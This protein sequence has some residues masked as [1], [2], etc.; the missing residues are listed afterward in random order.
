MYNI[1]VMAIDDILG[2]PIRRAI[3]LQ[4]SKAEEAND[5]N[6]L[7]VS[8]TKLC[9]G[10][11]L[12]KKLVI[13][14]N[15]MILINQQTTTTKKTVE[16]PSKWSYCLPDVLKLIG[17]K[18]KS[19]SYEIGQFNFQFAV[20]QNQ[21]WDILKKE[22]WLKKQVKFSSEI[23]DCQ[24]VKNRIALIDYLKKT[25]GQPVDEASL[26]KC[27]D[28][29]AE[30]VRTNL[31]RLIIS[32]K[33]NSLFSL[34][35]FH[36]KVNSL[37]TLLEK[38][39]IIVQEILSHEWQ[40]KVAAE[41]EIVVPKELDHRKSVLI[42][43]LKKHNGEKFVHES[44]QKLFEMSAEQT[45]SLA[46]TLEEKGVIQKVELCHGILNKEKANVEQLPEKLK[47][48]QD[49]LSSWVQQHL[50]SDQKSAVVVSRD[51]LL[52]PLD[53]KEDCRQMWNHLIGEGVIKEPVLVFPKIKDATTKII[54]SEQERIRTVINGLNI[55]PLCRKYC[56][57]PA[58]AADDY[59][60]GFCEVLSYLRANPSVLIKYGLFASLLV[61]DLNLAEKI[62]KEEGVKIKSWLKETKEKEAL[63]AYVNQVVAAVTGSAGQLKT[64]P[65]A[66]SASF[67][68][69][70]QYFTSG[71][72]PPEVDDF[73]VQLL[74]RVI[75]LKEYKSWWDW[76]AFIVA[77]I[78]VLQIAAGVAINYISAG[79]LS[80]IGT[81]L[82]GEGVNDIMFAI[83]SGLTGTFSWSGYG[84][85]KMVSAGITILTAGLATYSI[86]STALAKTAVATCRARIGL[87]MFLAAGKKILC[88]I[89][90]AARSA[91]I[92]LGVEK[93]MAFLKKFIVDHILD[94]IRSSLIGAAAL[95]AVKKMMEAMDK[96]WKSTDGDVKESKRLI[97]TTILV[98]AAASDMH[99]TWFK[100]LSS[101][102]TQLGMSMGNTFAEAS[103]EI[104]YQHGFLEGFGYGKPQKFENRTR[105]SIYEKGFRDG[106]R[107]DGTADSTASK[108]LNLA[109]DIFDLGKQVSEMIE[110]TETAMKWIGRLKTGTEVAT[111]ITHTPEY[112]QNI[113][114]QLENQAH[115][116][117]IKK[118]SNRNIPGASEEFENFK[119][120]MKTKVERDVL[121]HV[122]SRIN[123]A[124]LQPLVQRGVEKIVQKAGKEA[125]QF[126]G[127]LFDDDLDGLSEQRERVGKKETDKK[128]SSKDKKKKN[129][130][131]KQMNNESLLNGEP[132]EESYNDQ[133]NSIGGGKPAGL[134]EFQQVADYC[135]I[136]MEIDDPTGSLAPNSKDKT[137]FTVNSNGRE[138]EANGPRLTLKMSKNDDGTNHVTL[139]DASGKSIYEGPPDGLN[140]C[141]Y[142][143]AASFKGVP[144]EE[145]I[146]GL[147]SHALNNERTR[148]YLI[149][150]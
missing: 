82:I 105:Q 125:A 149:I 68:K 3:E 14:E 84:K 46:K 23:P 8:G 83:Q 145:F 65:A 13:D 70:D 66:I 15:N 95:G 111:I 56:P 24:Y 86:W 148:Y 9:K 44:I 112:I 54:E 17:D 91:L 20:T 50:Q 7:I 63:D 22:N 62:L 10:M 57:A 102:A 114:R 146:T 53:A 96:I 78:G 118:D 4:F 39:G 5:L 94:Y 131:K 99:S 16:W 150:F 88:K 109:K 2:R 40:I 29:T 72:Y 122:V 126:I 100:Q 116:L 64:F 85:Q 132:E 73:E 21:L 136:P 127:S 123:S 1:H 103:Q 101:H 69:L 58:A 128:E 32:F 97:Q 61:L 130:S 104:N 19:K 121:D 144:T 139:T 37:V 81:S 142:E 141:L 41:S 90:Q 36:L 11:R 31:L 67:R 49:I 89:G 51:S 27:L 77:M 43:Y 140:R 30:Q 28:L 143:A 35:P 137:K 33:I 108:V 52:L 93:L 74:D 107:P 38:K 119:S 129:R 71:R 113:G 34:I 120:E 117:E 75:V 133:V 25:N 98:D 48:F 6:N 12:S 92:A 135:G 147:K 110:A 47:K 42:D 80:P 138:P 76:R 115:S 124:W 87:T 59:K 106:F 60:P 26:Q 79:L 134:L 18:V 45:K 55:Q